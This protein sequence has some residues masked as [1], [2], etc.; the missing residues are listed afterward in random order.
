MQSEGKRE[1]I[2]SSQKRTSTSSAHHLPI[3]LHL[4]P[5]TLSALFLWINCLCSH[6]WP[7]LPLIYQLLPPLLNQIVPFSCIINFPLSTGQFPSGDTHRVISR[8]LK[9]KQQTFA[10]LLM[11]Y[12]SLDGYPPPLSS[13][14][15][16]SCHSKIPQESSVPTI[17]NGSFSTLSEIHS[18]HTFTTI[19][20]QTPVRISNEEHVIKESILMSPLT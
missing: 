9:T 1:A 19:L 7:I 10:C 14:F 8:I 6:L 11:A 15:L 13:H 5:Y 16:A 4:H 2:R 20:Y 17:S 3:Y 18:D 12:P